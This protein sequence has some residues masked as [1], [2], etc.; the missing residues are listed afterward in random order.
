MKA[1]PLTNKKLSL[2]T[3]TTNSYQKDNYPHNTDIHMQLQE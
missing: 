1:I 2:P 3:K